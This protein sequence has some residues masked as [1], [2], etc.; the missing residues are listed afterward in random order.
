MA[1]QEL[2]ITYYEKKPLECPVCEREF[3]KEKLLSGRGR[4]IAGKLTDELRRLYE[5]SKK[6]GKLNPLN[7]PIIVCPQ[8]YFAAFEKDFRKLPNE[9]K[10]KAMSYSNSRTQLLMQTVGQVDYDEKRNDLS[11]A[12]SYL[13]ALNSYSFFDKN[14]SPTFKKG[15]AALRGAWLFGDLRDASED[16]DEKKKFSYIQDMLYKKAY[17]FYRKMLDIQSSGEELLDG[18]QLGPDTDKDWAYQGFLYIVGILTL[19]L[20]FM[21]SDLE[22]RAKMYIEAKRIVSKLFGSGKKSRSKPSEIL[23]M[24]RDVYDKLTEYVKEIEEELGT[25]LD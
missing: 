14:V 21:E 19:K 25:K 13:L 9:S 7:Y 20:G 1:E 10:E 5:P 6:Y 24:S 18:I 3:P 4:L 2:R 15:L 8:C 12:A 11:G 22:K 17:F 16:D 23:D